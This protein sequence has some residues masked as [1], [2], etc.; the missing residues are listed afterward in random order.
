MKLIQVMYSIFTQDFLRE[1]QECQ[2]N[3]AEDHL[4]PFQLLKHRPVMYLHIFQLTL[5]LSQMDRYILRQRCSTLVS[6]QLLMPVFQYHELVVLLR[7]RLLRRLQ[8]LSVQSLP[9]TESLLHS[10]S[11]VQNSMLILRRSLHRANVSERC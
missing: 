3:T 4:Q 8:H 11:L 1:L 6:D 5:Y 9:S 10:H 7:L 2:M